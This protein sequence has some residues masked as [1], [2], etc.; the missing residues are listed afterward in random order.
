M[1]TRITATLTAFLS[2]LATGAIRGEM[3]MKNGTRAYSASAYSLE[4]DELIYVERHLERWRDGRLAERE[5][6]YEDAEGELIAEKEV[7][8]GTMPAA[9]SF[10]MTDY[11]TGL[12]E[13]ADVGAEN[14][15]L[16]SG[17]PDQDVQPKRVALPEQ[18][19]IDAGFDAFMREKFPEIAEGRTLDFEFAVPSAGRFFEFR[20]VPEGEVEFRNEPAIR[21]TMKPANLFLRLLVDPIE[22]LYD[23]DGR[24]LQFRGLSNVADADG[25]R[26]KARIV[27]DYP[28]DLPSFGQSPI[29]Q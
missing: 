6:T 19:V 7:R 27:F 2:L 29:A 25:D 13:R 26:Y 18:A 8:Y 16:Y 22:L 12:V 24:L 3:D 9:P 1:T 4:T 21:V 28:A 15:N 20:L 11:R 17:V 10:E 23:R 14:V 5:V